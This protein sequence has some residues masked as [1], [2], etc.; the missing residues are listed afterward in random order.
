MKPVLEAE[1][2]L[3]QRILSAFPNAEFSRHETDLYVKDFPG[4]RDWL[5]TNY[6]F[7]TDVQ[8]F[9]SAI[10]GSLWLDIPFAAW[11]EKYKS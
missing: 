3:K 10:D 4:L 6:L 1:P 2:T 11:N 9:R 5:K 8:P 7:H